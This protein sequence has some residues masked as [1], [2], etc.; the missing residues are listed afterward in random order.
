MENCLL[1]L[2]ADC[3]TYV[4]E[5]L[6]TW[7][8][9]NQQAVFL[10]M[11]WVNTMKTY[12]IIWLWFFFGLRIP[13]SRCHHLLRH[14]S[15]NRIIIILSNVNWLINS[16]I[17]Y[18]YHRNFMS[19]ML[20]S[21]WLTVHDPEYLHWND[22]PTEVRH[23]NHGSILLIPIRIVNNTLTT[24]KLKSQEMILFCA[25]LSTQRWFH[26][27]EARWVGLGQDLV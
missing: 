8:E 21:R 20:S 26:W 24:L 15:C 2:T 27:W 19:H 12:T 10:V 23:G 6:V 25:Q 13:S 11:T 1:T 18:T 3:F 4:K 7:S 5:N 16:L 22:P 9:K 14:I 17:L